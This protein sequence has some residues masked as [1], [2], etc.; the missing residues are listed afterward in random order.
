MGGPP[1][2]ILHCL[3]NWLF[4]LEKPRM[5]SSDKKRN[6]LSVLPY[7]I[8]KMH[9]LYLCPFFCIHCVFFA[10]LLENLSGDACSILTTYSLKN[11]TLTCDLIH[12]RASMSG[13]TSSPAHLVNVFPL[14]TGLNV[15]PSFNCENVRAIHLPCACESHSSVECIRCDGTN[16]HILQT[17]SILW[18]E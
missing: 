6:I 18:H 11:S 4:D 15:S 2:V 7:F 12:S 5:C 16:Q 13:A 3:S 14:P 9:Q 1:L 8:N 10:V 17:N